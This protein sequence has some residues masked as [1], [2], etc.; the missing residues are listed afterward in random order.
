MSKPTTAGEYVAG[1]DDALRPLFKALR[2]FVRKHAPD[3]RERLCMGMPAYF[4]RDGQRFYIADHS[5]HVNLGF[6]TGAS[7]ADPDELLEGTGKNLRHVKVRSKA[8]LTP[9]LARLVK[10]AARE[11]PRT[12]R[13]F[14]AVVERE[15]AG[16]FVRIPF[17]VRDAFGAARPK[18]LAR[19]GKGERIVTVATYGGAWFLSL[20][21][22]FRKTAEVDVGDEVRVTLELA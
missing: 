13:S 17:D 4:A 12:A 19:V 15:D 1:V 9:A 5:K 20:P 14:R 18:V 16:V 2:A 10:T 21:K 11:A 8:D 6:T 22:A 7:V 3:L